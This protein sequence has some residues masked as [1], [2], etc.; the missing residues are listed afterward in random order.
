M[1]DIFAISGVPGSPP[2]AFEKKPSRR[3]TTES[4]PSGRS[5]LSYV[6]RSAGSLPLEFKTPPLS[7]ELEQASM[8]DKRLDF[9]AAIEAKL[10][11]AGRPD[12]ANPLKECHT[13]HFFARCRSCKKTR[14]FWNRC[15]KVWCPVCQPG[16]AHN[17]V[18]EMQVHIDSL[19]QPK[20]IVL[21]V[22]NTT[23]L[24]RSRVKIIRKQ[25][26]ALLESKFCKT[27]RRDWVAS[28]VATREPI[29]RTSTPWRGGLA[30]LEVTKEKR[31]WH[32]H[33][34]A[35]VDARFVDNVHLAE[36]W[37]NRTK[38]AGH[39]TKVKDCRDKSYLAEIAKYAVKGSELARWKP[40]EIVEFVLAFNKVRSFWTFGTLYGDRS[41]FKAEIAEVR[42]KGKAC[43]CGCVHWDI[44][45]EQ[46]WEWEKLTKGALLGLPPPLLPAPITQLRFHV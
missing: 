10:T 17:R 4:G 37:F 5:I 22:R 12:L 18:Q 8:W 6:S 35:L 15:K 46:E 38:G 20:H 44:F 40:E 45:D 3:P 14:E 19:T 41:K 32:L 29:Y 43:E 26:N 39:I 1:I 36:E 30:S 11:E 2:P 33:I 16:I 34:H 28:D 27:G 13:D 21:T 7:S 9:K 25:F 42:E 23:I 31:G 24:T